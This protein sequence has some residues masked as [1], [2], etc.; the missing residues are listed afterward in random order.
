MKRPV[1]LLLLILP[2]LFFTNSNFAFAQ[3]EQ[4]HIDYELPYPGILP[5][6]PLYILKVARDHIVSFLISGPL[7]KAEFNLLQSDK[8]LAGGLSLFIK[9]K[10]KIR[11]AESTISKGENYFQETLEKVKESNRQGMDTKDIVRRLMDS[12]KKHQEILKSLQFANLLKRSE[13][14]EKEVSKLMP[15]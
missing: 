7:K 10:N 9:D 11:L 15:K 5:D 13:E 8:R 4:Q 2:L 3:E 14:F 1:F 6:N 12:S